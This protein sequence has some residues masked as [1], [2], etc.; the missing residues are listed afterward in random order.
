MTQTVV[1]LWYRSA[2]L[3]LGSS[4][5]SIAIDVWAAGCAMGELLLGY[6]LLDGDN[7]MSQL[8]KIFETLG[9]PT[10][11]IWPEIV[12][13]PMIASGKLNLR[14]EQEK[15]P[16]NNLNV[17]FPKISSV[18]YDLFQNMLAFD[19]K[20]RISAKDCLVHEYF[21]ST[22]YPK[23]QA[24]MPTYPTEHG[25]AVAVIAGEGHSRRKYEREYERSEVEVEALDVDSTGANSTSNGTSCQTSSTIGTSVKEV[26]VKVIS[27]NNLKRNHSAISSSK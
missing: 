1:T 23:E 21:Y 2:E 16:Y 19:P 10:A 26:K 25:E 14:R 17:I 22:P 24:F 9:C 20:K 6:P 4:E 7:E 12:K 5:Y 18:G 27:I 15:Y 3:L 11:R 8:N 13:M